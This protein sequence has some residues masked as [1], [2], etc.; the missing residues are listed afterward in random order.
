MELRHLEQVLEICRSGGF[1][2]AARR[3]GIAQP[4]LSQSIAR[5]EADLS[6]KLFERD[7]G[8]ARPTPFGSLVAERAEALL[9]GVNQLAH[10]LEQLA[11]G[12]EGRVRIAVGP[13]SRLKPLPQFMSELARRLPRLRVESCQETGPG[14]VE[15]L[16]EGRV[17]LAFGYSEHGIRYAD[18][19][20]KK[21]F[22]D[23]IVLVARSG[24]PAARLDAAG[25]TALLAW[26]FAIAALVPGFK[27][28]LGE[29]DPRQKDNLTAFVCDDYGLILQRA[30]DSDAIAAGPSFVFEDAVRA[31]RL[32]RLSTTLDLAYG[33]WMLT[34]AE[35]WRTPLMKALAE[36]AR[37]AVQACETG[38]P[39]ATSDMAHDRGRSG[40]TFG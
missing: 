9:H 16:H 28:W 30:L 15:A 11:R 5:L 20:R 35:R 32:S 8:A 14:A 12:E 23:R 37:L 3:L 27:R 24:H 36:I 6:I 7:H 21:L 34:T 31:G 22:E 2:G 38:H 18:L 26:P 10:D 25:P 19:I 17:D 33:C 40:W 39:V 4:T 29:L 1:S 13:A